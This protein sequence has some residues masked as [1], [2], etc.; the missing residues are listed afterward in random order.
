MHTTDGHRDL[1]TE[2]VQRANSVKKIIK[3][4][5]SDNI[6]FDEDL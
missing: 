3:F 6:G 5:K 4:L 2:S 1:E